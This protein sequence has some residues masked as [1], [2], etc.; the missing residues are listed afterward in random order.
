VSQ[1]SAASTEAPLAG[2]PPLDTSF[3]HQEINIP[4]N[5]SFLDLMI[6]A[7]NMVSQ[8]S[9]IE[10]ASAEDIAKYN[11]LQLTVL[12]KQYHLHAFM[13]SADK[14][15]ENGKTYATIKEEL[16]GILKKP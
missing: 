16:I 15:V 14:S 10:D 13:K 1:A 11:T 9:S 6:V 2:A 8:L 3:K 5:I 4:R 12:S 7:D